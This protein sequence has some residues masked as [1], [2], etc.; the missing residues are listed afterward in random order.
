MLEIETR[1]LLQNERMFKLKQPATL[2]LYD[3]LNIVWNQELKPSIFGV[4]A[5]RSMLR[6]SSELTVYNLILLVGFIFFIR[7]VRFNQTD[8]LWWAF[9]FIGVG[10]FILLLA[11]H[12]YPSYLVTR[13]I[14]LG[15]QGRYLFIVIVPA[16]LV[17]S[18]FLLRNISKWM[19]VLVVMLVGFIFI[20]GDFPYF[21]EH[22]P[23]SWR[24]P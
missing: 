16:Y 15:T 22:A 24:A 7:N 3:Y 1:H 18:E 12:H 13:N 14:S 10:Y 17:L 19:Q 8:S 2:N 23:I 21:L 11:F 4:L 9:A 6:S 20:N 5:H